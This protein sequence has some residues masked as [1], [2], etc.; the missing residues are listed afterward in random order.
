M[1]KLDEIT[2]NGVDIIRFD[3]AGKIVE[4]K[5][6]IRPLKA[7]QKIQSQMAQML[8]AMKKSA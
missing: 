3:D 2:V 7:I 6:M 1:T 5:V 4:F 8:D